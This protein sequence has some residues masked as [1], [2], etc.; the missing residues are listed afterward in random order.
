M[1]WYKGSHRG[2]TDGQGGHTKQGEGREDSGQ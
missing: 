1:C 2:K